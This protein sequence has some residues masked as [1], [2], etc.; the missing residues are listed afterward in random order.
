MQTVA[1]KRYNLSM[2][3]ARLW[4]LQ[5]ESNAYHTQCAI[6]MDGALTIETLQQAIQHVIQQ[7]TI[8]QTSFRCMPGMDVPV[9]VVNSHE[10]TTE[11]VVIGLD[12]LFTSTQ[13]LTIQTCFTIAQHKQV[14]FTQN[15]LLRIWLFRLSLQTHI[16]LINLPALCADDT[17]ILQ[18]IT[19]LSQTYRLMAQH[20]HWATKQEEPLQ[21]VD[22][23][24]WQDEVLQEEDAETHRQFWRK[25]DL[26]QLA[27]MYL[28]LASDR[29][30][31][32]HD[33]Q[34]FWP[35][36]VHLPVEASLATQIRLLTDTYH[37]LPSAYLLTCWHILLQ[38]LM[39]NV[40]P[41]IGV[42][43]DGRI[44]AELASSL[45]LY[46]RLVPID[47]HLTYSVP[48]EQLLL[49]INTSLEKA[50]EEQIYFTWEDDS[51][52]TAMSLTT[53]HYF[54][55]SFEHHTWPA[56]FNAGA[57][58]FSLVK[59]SS[60]FEP[61]V[62]KLS[63][64][65]VGDSLQLELH[66]DPQRID[67]TLVS[68]IATIFH[69][70]LQAGLQQPHTAV[71]TLPLL[72]FD[73]QT[74]LLA[75]GR[76]ATRS[77]PDLRLHQLFEQQAQRLPDHLAVI[78]TQEQL[79]FQQLNERANQ[80]AWVLQQQGV[81]PNVLVG[82]CMT[83]STQ[84][85]IGLLGILKA[86]GAYLPLDPENP[87]ARF[88]H[89][90]QESQAILLLTQQGL[91]QQLPSWEGKTL[92]LEALEPDLLQSSTS[93]LPTRCDAQDLAYIIYTSG[94]TGMPKGVMIQQSGVVNYTLALCELLGSKTG[95]HYATVST[96]A[97]DL[98][99]TA[100]FCALASGG[101]LQVLDYETVTSS[102]K[103]ARW[104]AQHPIDVLKIVPSHLSAL[105]ADERAHAAMLPQRALI[106]GGEA[107]P[108]SLLTRLRELH[109]TC[110][111]YNHYGPTE[112]TI[113][114]LVYP[115]SDL[116][117]QEVTT[118]PLGK[119]ITNSEVYILD[120]NMQ[121]VPVGIIGELYIGGKGLAITYVQQPA[122][123]AARFIPHPF[124][125][126]GERLYRT[127]DLARYT[128]QG[129]IEFIG[130]G[131]SQIKLRGYRIELGEIEMAIRQHP[132]VRNSAVLLRND[133]PG[134]PHLVSYVVTHKRAHLQSEQVNEFCANLYQSI[135]S[136][137]S[138]FS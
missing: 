32:E 98:G 17:T 119:P 132:Q 121:L 80:L 81:G 52:S 61:F 115:F 94:S 117:I 25:T 46:T 92:S 5:G 103:L 134:G 26:S 53:P 97:A 69:T 29:Q 57:L 126:Y 67:S 33:G 9:Q 48:F 84:M 125:P 20:M 72:T 86:G 91:L 135:C 104:A 76:T 118:V 11:C 27:T 111:I 74:A 55:I 21:Y 4:S 122:Q 56:S 138:G 77:L 43:F 30:A 116:A 87:S 96:L 1:A 71:D 38:R 107:L 62:L 137:R 101:C 114:T 31:R 14:D 22:V 102:E 129:T 124:G 106:C 128:A 78:S 42:A 63:S 131:D 16:L 12:N 45:G 88:K 50:H 123:T 36:V 109:V 8:L 23:A 41:I 89:M 15:S 82:L 35:E 110:Q 99:N 113:G 58:S 34:P 40:A 64:L 108:V 136:L 112:T 85:I 105:L 2:Q 133:V 83:R 73:E 39:N 37:V 6:Q 59:R 100:I 44:D 75:M 7:H 68:Q 19:E 70:L 10:E 95:W 130:R 51:S 93:N 60:C 3:Q 79:T 13:E 28:P 120:A 24:A 18:F 49:L 90:L 127:G 54:P 66:Y 65:Q 47:V